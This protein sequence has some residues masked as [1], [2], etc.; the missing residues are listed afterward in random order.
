MP[1]NTVEC[2]GCALLHFKSSNG[3]RPTHCPFC[4][5]VLHPISLATPLIVP[6][7]INLNHDHIGSVLDCYAKNGLRIM[8][9]FMIAIRTDPSTDELARK[10][11][12]FAVRA[13]Y[14]NGRGIVV[15]PQ[16]KWYEHEQGLQKITDDL[17]KAQTALEIATTAQR[18]IEAK[19]RHSQATETSLQ[20]AQAELR[21]LQQKVTDAEETRKLRDQKLLDTV[22]QLILFDQ[23]FHEYEI[24]DPENVEVQ[25][26][27]METFDAFHSLI[28]QGYKVPPALSESLT[29]L[30]ESKI[31]G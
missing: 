7:T 12:E 18:N 21:T 17:S 30:I 22:N 10:L 15:M 5:S 8:N 9:E 2:Q 24:D 20:I 1:V 26:L 27:E 19:L 29:S 23:F 16:T 6:A 11:Y 31:E 13:G 4:R 14:P 3:T 28:V 25:K